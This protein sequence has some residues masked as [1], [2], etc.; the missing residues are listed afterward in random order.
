[1]TD[2]LTNSLSCFNNHLTFYRFNELR[3]VNLKELNEADLPLL[4]SEFE[5]LVKKQCW[6][7]HEVLRKR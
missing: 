4:P 5:S 1:M 2:P 3:F 6:E 7:A